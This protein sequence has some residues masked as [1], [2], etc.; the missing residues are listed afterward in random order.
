MDTDTL[1]MPINADDPMLRLAVA[2][3]LAR[4]KGRTRAHTASR[5]VASPS[6]WSTSCA[7]WST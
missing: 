6:T 1:P 5:S 2:A 4:Y 3:H 7:G